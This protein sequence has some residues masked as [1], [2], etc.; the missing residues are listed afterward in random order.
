MAERHKTF[1]LRYVGAR[2]SGARLPLDVLSDLPA[3]RDLLVSYAKDKWRSVNTGRKRLPK[4]FDKSISLDLIAIEDGSAMPKLDW[5][6]DMAQAMLPEFDDEMEKLVEDS[7]VELVALIDGAGHE[8]FPQALSSEQIRA[9]NSLG[10][11]LFDGERIE[12]LGSKGV[13]GKVVFLDNYR[14]KELITRVRETYQTRYEDIGRL[15][16]LHVGGHIEIATA[17]YGELQLKVDSGRVRDEFDGNVDGD[18]Q[19]S[20]LIELN[21]KDEIRGVVSVF[22][23]DLID[24]EVSES[25]KRCFGRLGQLRGLQDG[26]NAGS[27]ASVVD[28]AALA[29]RRFLLNRS[30][31]ADAYRL[32]PKEDGGVLVEFQTRGWDFTVEFG[33]SGKIEMFGVEID[34]PKEMDTTEYAQLNDEFFS[35]FDKWTRGEYEP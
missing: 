22:D 9:L 17:K 5:S 4:G 16:G 15:V 33:F 20:I 6:R 27:G 8:L 10:S 21:N 13:D 2:F 32:Y 31:F 23:V 3:F 28:A 35:D 34:G 25:L 30:E 24:A 11:S 1:Q 29:V 12:F 14:R 18:V 7:Y 26:W 19:F